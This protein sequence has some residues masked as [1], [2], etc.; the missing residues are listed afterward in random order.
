MRIVGFFLRAA[1]IAMA[2]LGFATVIVAGV[3]C[4]ILWTILPPLLVVLLIDGLK[5][6]I[7]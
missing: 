3:M 4:F 1:V 7:S 6:L 2:L 5:D